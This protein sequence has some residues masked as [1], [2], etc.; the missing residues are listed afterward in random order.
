MFGSVAGLVRAARQFLTQASPNVLGNEASQAHFGYSLAVNDFNGDGYS[1]LAAGVP[2]QSVSGVAKAGVAIISFGGTSGLAGSTGQTI[3][4]AIPQLAAI[5][6]PEDRFGE[7]MAA[8][9]FDHDG[10]SDLAVG[11]PARDT[12][13]AGALTVVYGRANGFTAQGAQY[14]SQALISPTPSTGDRF[15]QALEV[16]DFNADG[17]Q[18]LATGQ[19]GDDISGAAD[20]GSFTIQYGARPLAT[21]DD[22]QRR[23]RSLSRIGGTLASLAG[24]PGPTPEPT[25]PEEPDPGGP[26]P[27]SDPDAHVCSTIEPLPTPTPPRSPGN[28]TDRPLVLQA[29]G[30]VNC[31]WYRNSLT[32]RFLGGAPDVRA[33]IE[34]LAHEWEPWTGITFQFVNGG[35]ADIRI[36]FDRTGGSWSYVGKCRSYDDANQANMN[37]G[38][39]ET[40]ADALRFKSPQTSEADVLEAERLEYRRVVLHEFGHALGL[41]HEHQSPSA[42]IQWNQEV[43]IREMLEENSSW[44]RDRVIANIF[45]RYSL[46]STNYT[47]YDPDSIM[48]YSFPS[49]WTVDGFS[50]KHNYDLSERDRNFMTTWNSTEP[51]LDALSNEPEAEYFAGNWDGIGGDN[52][53]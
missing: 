33:R 34:S 22:L 5:P 41:I 35:I 42:N 43:V 10:F 4:L 21:P 32:V 17:F 24:R 53:C 18:D 25:D 15:G 38:W 2:G 28:P 19:P 6:A 11:I 23:L 16:G 36:G 3:S 46:S 44:T 51:W 30:D 29:A 27:E 45:S 12:G 8:A 31:K 37:F 40:Y 9:D 7:A 39:L 49:R 13:D 20:A 26:D 14:I 50:Q 52:L 47:A 48:V 1:D